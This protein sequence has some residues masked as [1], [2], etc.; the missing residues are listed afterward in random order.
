[1]V[2]HDIEVMPGTIWEELNMFNEDIFEGKLNLEYNS[3]KQYMTIE[4]SDPDTGDLDFIV[5]AKFLTLNNT[6]D[7]D[8]Y[9]GEP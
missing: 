5:K 3:D 2:D 9:E 6:E 1:M 4:M 8:T 7:Q